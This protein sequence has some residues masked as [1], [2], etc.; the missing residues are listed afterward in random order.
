MQFKSPYAKWACR[1]GL[2]P[3]RREN[4]R[5]RWSFLKV[6]S[7]H[8]DASFRHLLARISRIDGLVAD[9]WDMAPLT[10]AEPRDFWGILRALPDRVCDPDIVGASCAPAQ[11]DRRS[12]ADGI[13][14]RLV[15]NVHRIE[16]SCDSMRKTARAEAG[17]L[18]L[19]EELELAESFLL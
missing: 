10:E 5:R 13:L 8:P 9:N 17:A 16:I 3:Y 2:R 1:V 12:H 6:A 4:A 14:D 11:A 15:N 18:T 7:A 19:I